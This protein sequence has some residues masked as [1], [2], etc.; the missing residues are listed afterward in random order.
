M[1]A[2]SII[3]WSWPNTVAHQDW[4]LMW[5]LGGGAFSALVDDDNS[6]D[7][8]QFVLWAG[9][10]LVFRELS[11]R[12]VSYGFK[13]TLSSSHSLVVSFW[14]LFMGYLWLVD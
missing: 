3:W 1:K 2:L 10:G 7:D 14:P 11:L 9:G 6:S 8:A 12:L 13:F 4:R 5:D